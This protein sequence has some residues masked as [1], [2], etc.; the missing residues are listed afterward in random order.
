MWPQN[1]MQDGKIHNKNDWQFDPFLDQPLWQYLCFAK[2]FRS[3]VI[4]RMFWRQNDRWQA[5]SQIPLVFCS[6]T[7]RLDSCNCSIEMAEDPTMTSHL[8][9]GLYHL[10]NG[11][12]MGFNRVRQKVWNLTDASSP[13]WV[14]DK[15]QSWQRHL[16][17]WCY[18]KTWLGK[19]TEV[20]QLRVIFWFISHDCSGIHGRTFNLSPLHSLFNSFSK[21]SQHHVN[22]PMLLWLFEDCYELS[23]S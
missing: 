15:C 12:C 8:L 19:I 17:S 7:S 6:P 16:S 11:G 21:S 18:G 22:L 3:L 1:K 23:N 20:S 4:L 5:P 13:T 2:Q 14:A 10:E 9:S